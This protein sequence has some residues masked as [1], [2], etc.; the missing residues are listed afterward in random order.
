MTDHVRITAYG[1]FYNFPGIQSNASFRI[2][3]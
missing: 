1:P 2:F 3:P